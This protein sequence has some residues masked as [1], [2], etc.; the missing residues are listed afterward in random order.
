MT[1]VVVEHVMPV[2]LELCD[3]LLVIHYGEKIAEGLP[4]D[5]TRDPKVLE[6]Y[7]GNGSYP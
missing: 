7:L 1:L 6:A 5:V 3:R 4:A 2:I